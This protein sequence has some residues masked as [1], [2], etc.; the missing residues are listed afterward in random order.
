MFISYLKRTINLIIIFL[1]LC[2]LKVLGQTSTP[3][4]TPTSTFTFTPTLPP[5]QG[6]NVISASQMLPVYG[7]PHLASPT[8]GTAQHLNVDNSAGD[9]YYVLG[10][11]QIIQAIGYVPVAYGSVA[12]DT[13]KVSNFKI[14]AHLII[15]ANF[16][17]EAAPYA[18]KLRVYAYEIDTSEII[19]PVTPSANMFSCKSII[20]I[21]AATPGATTPTPAGNPLYMDLSNTSETPVAAN[22]TAAIS[23][24]LSPV[25][26]KIISNAGGHRVPTAQTTP[27]QLCGIRPGTD[28]V[29]CTDGYPMAICVMNTGS[30][31]VYLSRLYYMW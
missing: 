8:P 30:S 15:P 11:G 5:Y 29:P 31:T 14:G 10:S 22:A 1:L 20:E 24:K 2:P 13:T 6:L 4:S 3:T 9:S 26:L 23:Y 16:T 27:A 21:Y 28:P 12:S 17:P 19:D 18:P 25:D 7:T